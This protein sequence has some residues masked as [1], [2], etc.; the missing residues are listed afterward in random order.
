MENINV[1]IDRLEQIITKADPSLS[2]AQKA[3]NITD[4]LKKV[5]NTQKAQIQKL[6]EKEED[7]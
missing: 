5:I 4:A 6:K 3:F 7:N 1:L 2:E